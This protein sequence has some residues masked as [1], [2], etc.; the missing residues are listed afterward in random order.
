[1]LRQGCCTLNHEATLAELADLE[2]GTLK[3]PEGAHDD[4]AMAFI[5]ALAGLR[6]ASFEHNRGE[7]ISF[8]IEY[9][10]VLDDLS[11]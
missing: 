5:N 7:G 4:L 2:A 6:W 9:P 3:A 10:D 11:F 8:V 1:V